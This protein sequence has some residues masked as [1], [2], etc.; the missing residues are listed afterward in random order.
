MSHYI[1]Y[2]FHTKDNIPEL[3][4]RDLLTLHISNGHLPL[5]SS[6]LSIPSSIHSVIPAV[7]E[8]ISIVLVLTEYWIVHKMKE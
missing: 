3:Y 6:A 7:N 5:Q 8:R 4:V 2:S 1:I